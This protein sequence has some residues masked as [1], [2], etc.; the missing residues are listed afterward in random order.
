MLA[1]WQAV[2]PIPPARHSKSAWAKGW[3]LELHL[4]RKLQFLVEVYFGDTAED[5]PFLA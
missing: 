2:M 5:F 1:G 4:K 3:L